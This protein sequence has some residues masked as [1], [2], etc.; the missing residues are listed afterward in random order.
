KPDFRSAFEGGREQQRAE[1]PSIARSNRLAEE[2]PNVASLPRT[3]P[4]QGAWYVL[5]AACLDECK[6]VFRPAVPV[7]VHREKPTGFISE[8]RIHTGDERGRVTSSAY[9]TPQVILDHV[10]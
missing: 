7:E 3:R 5:H 1:L 9:L 4:L 10:V 2:N 8:E 6:R